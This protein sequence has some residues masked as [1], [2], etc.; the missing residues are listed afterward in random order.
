MAGK[1][2]SNDVV[3][4]NVDTRSKGDATE[5]AAAILNGATTTLSTVIV[6]ACWA[7]DTVTPC[8]TVDV[9]R[10][11]PRTAMFTSRTDTGNVDSSRV[12]KSKPR[13]TRRACF[14]ATAATRIK[15]RGGGEGRGGAVTR[16][17]RA[18]RDLKTKHH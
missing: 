11:P 18:R 15:G 12:A 7:L 14:A 16:A 1:A 4:V 2:P 5:A 17:E 8:T 10:V 3:S 13:L 9:S 6:T